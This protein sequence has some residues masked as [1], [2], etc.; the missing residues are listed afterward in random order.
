MAKQRK[1]KFF[2]LRPTRL[3]SNT[4]FLAGLL[5]DACYWLSEKSFLQRSSGWTFYKETHPID[6][7]GLVYII[8]L[9]LC[10]KYMADTQS[11]SKNQFRKLN[12]KQNVQ[13]EKTI[14]TLF[15]NVILEIPQY[16]SIAELKQAQFLFNCL[17][18]YFSTKA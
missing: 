10:D 1:T 9:F 5:A 4:F 2:L 14:H 18:W 6:W 17:E 15:N 3:K 12:R 8:T 7:V 16:I 13:T 11:Y